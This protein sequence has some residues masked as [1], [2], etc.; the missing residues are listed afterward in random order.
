[1]DMS[2]SVLRDWARAVVRRV[3]M[4]RT[5]R[6]V[7]CSSSSSQSAMTDPG[8]GGGHQLL[9]RGSDLGGVGLGQRGVVGG[10]DEAAGSVGEGDLGELLGPLAGWALEEA[11][12][13]GGEL[14]G[15]VEEAADVAW[16]PTCGEGGVVDVPV[17]LGELGQAPLQVLDRRKP[18]VRGATDQAQDA[19][20]VGADPDADGVCGSR[21]AFG[22]ADVVVLAADGQD[23]A[24]AGVP[25]AADDRDRLLE[26]L[27]G[28][29]GSASGATHAGYAIPERAGTDAQ[30][31]PPAAEQ[32]QGG[33]GSGEHGW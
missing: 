23:A 9:D 13:L 26:R 33:D 32:V 15:D 24:V 3:C 8:A 6:Q 18:A 27:D 20:L 10:E 5:L 16:F 29:P 25:D 14:S 4:R 1:M 17:H 11:A 22:A 30:L 31:D 12:S 7:R 21:A 28:L 2:E 19:G